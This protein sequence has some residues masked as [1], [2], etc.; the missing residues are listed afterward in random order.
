MGVVWSQK[1]S[2]DFRTKLW[3]RLTILNSI[4]CMYPCCHEI[5]FLNWHKQRMDLTR[6]KKKKKTKTPKPTL[7]IFTFRVGGPYLLH[8]C[9]RGSALELF[10]EVL[11]PPLCLEQLLLEL[12]ELFP[13]HRGTALLLGALAKHP[14]GLQ[15]L[16]KAKIPTSAPAPS[17]RAAP[18]A[19]R[20]QISHLQEK[21]GLG[22]RR[23][24]KDGISHKGSWA[25]IHHFRPEW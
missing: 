9:P 15:H 1:N 5:S 10:L 16:Q 20:S 25:L 2:E 21:P 4:F 18:G 11:T 13:G 3:L 19:A 17:A 24:Q 12:Q 7:K 22:E 8:V 23:W 14:P 6:I